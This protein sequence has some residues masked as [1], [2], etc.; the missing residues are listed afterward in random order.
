MSEDLK[1]KFKEKRMNAMP[2]IGKAINDFCID[3]KI[4]NVVFVDRFARP[5][6]KVFKEYWDTHTTSKRP[7]IYFISPQA[8]ESFG[9]NDD[10]V[11]NLFRKE[12]PYLT[13]ESKP[14]LI[15]DVCIKEG[16]TMQNLTDLFNKT[17]FDSVYTMVTATHN[18]KK[19]YFKPDKVLFEDHKLGCH[20]FGAFFNKEVG[21]KRNEYS[22]LTKGDYSNNRDNLLQNR[23]D[24]KNSIRN[25]VQQ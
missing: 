25:Y 8:L 19:S 11:I 18:D 20:L 15:F 1:R 16:V 3:N 21:V 4:E 6:Y 22:L 14:T 17:G 9:V 10:D 2:H 24:L 7:N 13:K 5:A 23:K 12:H